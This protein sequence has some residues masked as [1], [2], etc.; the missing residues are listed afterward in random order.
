MSNGGKLIY[1]IGANDGVDTAY[2]LA[3][4]CSV[5]A[6][7]ADPVLAGGLRDRFAGEIA[8]GRVTVVNAAVMAED[9]DEVGFY[10]SKDNTE[11]SLIQSMA[12]RAGPVTG[13]IAVK[14][15]SLC[16]LF[17]EYG[18][19]WYCKIDI[20]GCDAA[21]V[22]G[23]S[24]CDRRPAY[25]SCESTGQPIGQISQDEGLL[26]EVLDALAAQ[27]YRQ[28]KLVDQESLQV[29]TDSGHYNRL[30]RWPVRARTKLERWV[31]RPTPRYNNRLWLSRRGLPGAGT[32]SGPFGT[33]L[34][35]EWADYKAIR[36]RM[37]RHFSHYYRYT[38]NKQFIFW[39][40]IHGKF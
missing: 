3:L 33:Q 31:G 35:G 34:A 13:Q 36:R 27:G 17:S 6:I 21:A 24:G 26:C 14:G 40:D 4:G 11:S 20:E 39:V 1:D 12:E 25:I 5:V 23:M 38:K 2:Y 30:Q 10:I 16:S 7:E 28:F 15:R 18:L 9:R 32:V 37:L 22:S 29:L 8:G 19:P